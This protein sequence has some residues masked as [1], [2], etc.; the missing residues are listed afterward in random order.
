M[1]ADGFHATQ[2]FDKLAAAILIVGPSW[3]VNEIEVNVGGRHYCAIV[4][5]RC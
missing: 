5:P 2:E 1:D 3:R 4:S